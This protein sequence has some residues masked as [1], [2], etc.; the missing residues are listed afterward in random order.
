METLLEKARRLKIQPLKPVITPERRQEVVGMAQEAITAKTEAE[1]K[2]GFMGQ[3]KSFGEEFVKRLGEITGITPTGKRIAAGVAPYVVPK[4][5][6]PGVVEELVGGVIT[7]EKPKAIELAE[8]AI[9]L[10]LISLGLSKTISGTLEK[11]AI[12]TAPELAKF[13]EKP[14]LEF[15][16]DALRKLLQKEIPIKETI[17]EFAET[18][19]IARVEKLKTQVD[20]AIGRIIQGKPE[21]ISSA[22]KALNLIDTEGITTYKELNESVGDSIGTIANKLDTFL[23]EQKGVYK[24]KDLVTSVQVGEKIVKHNYLEDAI[25]HLKEL[26]LKTNDPT[27][28]TRIKQIESKLGKEGLNVKEINDLSKT[29]GR[30]FGEKAFSK[31]GDPLTSINS[32]AYENTRKGLKTTARSKIEGNTA[33]TLDEQMSS[34][35]DLQ[36]LTAKMEVKVNNLYQKIKKRGLVERIAMKLGTA[37]DVA[38]LR[39]ASGFLSRML[40][41]NVG[42]KTMNSLDIQNELAK[43]LS[44]V[45][46]LLESENDKIIE[47]GITNLIMKSQKTEIKGI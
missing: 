27:S 37:I 13:L 34:L 41:S 8:I 23:A 25:K 15:A 43:N 12:K 32:Q 47:D 26:Y 28:F 44:L 40:P 1:E 45:E 46:K 5:E 42:L 16:P 11:Q 7:P 4:E 18:R 33:K 20:E 35:Y 2:A 17:K 31:M 22:K 38:T 21:D 30:E 19:R 9:D 39:S 3:L 24:A 6:L 14:L 10:P 29:Y 36:R